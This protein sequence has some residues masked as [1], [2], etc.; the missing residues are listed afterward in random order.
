M[1]Q[2][3]AEDLGIDEQDNDPGPSYAPLFKMIQELQ[4]Q[5][6]ELR[7]QVEKLQLAMLS[8]VESNYKFDIVR[9]SNGLIE[10]VNAVPQTTIMG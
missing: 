1:L 7:E 10:T 8:K 9:D 6:I 3:K 5:N 2:L 4:K